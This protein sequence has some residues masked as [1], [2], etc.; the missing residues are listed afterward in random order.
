VFVGISARLMETK[1][2]KLIEFVHGELRKQKR[3]G[4]SRFNGRTMLHFAARWSCLAII[5]QLIEDGVDPN[6]LDSGGHT[7]LY[8]SAA[9]ESSDM[10]SLVVGELVRAG[11]NVDHAGGVNRSTALHEAARHGNLA[12]A[13][14]LL[15]FGANK[16]AKDRKSLTPL[17]RARNLKRSG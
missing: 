8:R 11:A 16:L 15:D 13:K 6:V 2:E 9:G 5:R 3:L 17:D 4:T 14:A 12:V 1:R 7:A 10:A